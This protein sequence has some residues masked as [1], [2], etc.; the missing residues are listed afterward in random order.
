MAYD[1]RRR[2]TGHNQYTSTPRKIFD[3]HVD[4]M[5]TKRL[6]DKQDHRADMQTL[7]QRLEKLEKQLF[8]LLPKEE[9]VQAQSGMEL[10]Q[11]P[12]GR[13]RKRSTEGL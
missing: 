10:I 11:L 5:E 1:K 7:L 8:Q 13:W 3:K 9:E 6:R 2:D 12:D 4:R